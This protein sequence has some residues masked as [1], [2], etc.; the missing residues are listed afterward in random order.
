MNLDLS[1]ELDRKKA[2]SRLNKLMLKG[3]RIELKAYQGGKTYSQLKYLHAIIKI[4]A[5]ENKLT[6]REAKELIKYS[7][8]YTY[9]KEG[10]EFL[11]SFQDA[12][13]EELFV[14][15]QNFRTWSDTNGTYLMSA[16]EY[17][18]QIDE[19]EFEVGKF[20]HHLQC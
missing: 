13:K 12:S 19:V 1:K 5:F 6:L 3:A 17:K 14:F 15:I 20:K 11:K 9:K 8:D 2:Q 18:G 16:D 7:L 10:Y 4:W